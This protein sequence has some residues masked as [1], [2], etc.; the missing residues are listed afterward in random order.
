MVISR[1]MVLLYDEL[2]DGILCCACNQQALLLVVG[3]RG[4]RCNRCIKTNEILGAK[5]S[6][7]DIQ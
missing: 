5:Q 4:R 6:F 2:V 7:V 3:L 1:M